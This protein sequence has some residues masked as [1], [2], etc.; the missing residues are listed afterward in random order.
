VLPEPFTINRIFN[1]AMVAVLLMSTVGLAGAQLPDF[2]PA[3][4]QLVPEPGTL[5]L[6]GMGLVGMLTV[7]R[8][9][10]T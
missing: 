9:R 6:V 3:P 1:W 8:R 5:T 7:L 10:R 2:A 4:Q